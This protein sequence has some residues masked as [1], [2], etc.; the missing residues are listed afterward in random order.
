MMI[1]DAEGAI[2]GRLSS[3][4]AK[5]L[6]RGEDIEII[7][8]EKAVVSGNSKAVIERF[9][10]RRERGTPL[11]GPFYPKY[12][13]RILRRAIRGMLPYKKDRGR[14]AFKRLKIYMGN[15]KNLNGE[16]ISK[17][18]DELKIKY[19]TLEDISKALGAKLG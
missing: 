9:S 11:K 7:N 5:M 10:A 1:V 3:R 18:A 19:T 6:L 12:P 2:L 13:D 4:V 17:T 16:R 14:K 15:P 8:A